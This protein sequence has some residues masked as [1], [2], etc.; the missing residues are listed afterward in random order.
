MLLRLSEQGYALSLDEHGQ[1]WATVGVTRD[2]REAV[3]LYSAEPV[4]QLPSLVELRSGQ[5]ALRLAARLS[6]R[7]PAAS[8][9][10]QPV[11][12]SPT[13]ASA[14]AADDVRYSQD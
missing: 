10:P 8:D 11:D 14:P 3:G 7:T 6:R 5:A 13:G 12:G 9:S 1:P 2:G 4:T